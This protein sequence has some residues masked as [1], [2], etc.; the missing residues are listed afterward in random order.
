YLLNDTYD[1]WR[2]ALDGS[3]GTR[4]T[5]GAKDGVVHR[6][7]NFAPFTASAEDRAFDLSKPLY[8]S[9]RGKKTKQSGY[10]RVNPDGKVERLVLAD[11][12][13]S[14]LAR[15]DSAPVFAY[16]RQRYDESP[17][18]KVGTDV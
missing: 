2:I 4:L 18:L 16:A 5:D 11:A 12:A 8:L 13:Y 10:A 6:L 15:A 9:L 14:A 3:G 7:I 1:V 17:S